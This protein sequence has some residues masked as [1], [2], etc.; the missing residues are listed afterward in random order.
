MKWSFFIF[1]ASFLNQQNNC[2]HAER[3]IVIP[4]INLYIPKMKKLILSALLVPLLWLSQSCD[5]PKTANKNAAETTVDAMGLD[6]ITTASEAGHA[7]IRASTVAENVSKN[8]RV[9]A[10]AK[11]MVAD[12]SAAGA[13][14]DKLKADELVQ[15]P[16]EINADHVKMIDSLSKLT[17]GDFDK[18][19]MQMMVNDHKDAVNVFDEGRENRAEAVKS[20]AEKTLPTIEMHLDSA[21]AVLASLK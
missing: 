13:K 20:Y 12:H 3:S 19:Y 1:K 18:A 10:F 6:F 17:G 7:E 11:M 21:K 4:S 14:L 15:Q 8:P 5:D 9:I 16:N 2:K